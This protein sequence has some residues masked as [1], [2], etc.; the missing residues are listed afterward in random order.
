MFRIYIFV[1]CDFIFSVYE[2]LCVC[3][4]VA[5]QLSVLMSNAMSWAFASYWV[6]QT[7]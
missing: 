5:R 3:I 6:L 7:T 2:E 1:I 4:E